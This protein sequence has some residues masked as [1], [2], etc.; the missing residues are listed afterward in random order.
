M[1]NKNWKIIINEQEYIINYERLKINTVQDIWDVINDKYIT[2]NNIDEI[3]SIIN[4]YENMEQNT[5]E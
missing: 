5:N 1:N 2:E 3:K 4:K